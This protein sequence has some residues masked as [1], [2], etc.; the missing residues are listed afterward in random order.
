MHRVG[1]K[2]VLVDVP[3]N[4]FYQR[5]GVPPTATVEQIKAA[6]RRKALRLHPDK[7]PDPEATTRFQACSEAY[8]LLSDARRR[9][10]YDAKQLSEAG[11]GDLV[12]G[13]IS[14][15]FGGRFRRKRAGRDV[16]YVLEL[17]LE[18]VVTLVRR[19]I[20]IAVDEICPAC[21]GSGAA[22]GGEA[23]CETCQGR[24]ASSGPGLLSWPRPCP[25]CGGQ[26]RRV[27]NPCGRCD[28]VGM[29]VVERRFDVTLP[30]GV[31][32]GDIRVVPGQGEPGLYGGAPGDLNV[33]VRIR[34][35][36]LF[37]RRDRDIS[38][39]I[40]VGL[41]LVA[42]GGTLEVPTLDGKVRMRVPPGTQ[43]GRVF[44]IKGRGIAGGDLLAR[45]VVE[46][47]V[48]L[49]VEG[50]TL[51]EALRKVNGDTQFPRRTKYRE[52]VDGVSEARD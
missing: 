22:P 50:Q 39:D 18:D 27:V 2:V 11:A 16:R 43:S 7:N 13:L 36:D 25:H 26:G 52:T 21:S 48:G 23:I 44:R 38:L 1:T 30:A 20:A 32:D 10:E 46:T 8:A 31:R 34:P 6:Y 28:G 29:V 5:L 51:L 40:P 41:P 12:G 33:V 14:E 3:T 47:P 49:S 17:T 4:D 42:L 19:R 9:Q 45:L 24:G 37:E 15:I 35:H